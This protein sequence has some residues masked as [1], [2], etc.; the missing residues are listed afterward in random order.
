M[1]QTRLF[2]KIAAESNGCGVTV[3]WLDAQETGAW[4]GPESKILE[5]VPTHAQAASVG[6]RK[7]DSLAAGIQ[8]DCLL[9]TSDA[10]DEQCMV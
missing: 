5:P 3:P 1:Q 9:Y 10:A 4:L 6:A 2:R 8:K 7:I